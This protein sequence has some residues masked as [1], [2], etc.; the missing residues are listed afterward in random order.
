MD[1][2][3]MKEESAKRVK[4]DLD[5]SDVSAGHLTQSD[6]Q[7]REPDTVNSHQSAPVSCVSTSVF[8]S[9]GLSISQQPA[10]LV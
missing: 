7:I 1:R 5:T 10:T 8:S 2:K 6:V 4:S 3:R 9:H